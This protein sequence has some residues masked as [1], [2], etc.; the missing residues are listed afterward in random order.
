MEPAR[1]RRKNWPWFHFRHGQR[2]GQTFADGN[3]HNSI[4]AFEDGNDA[5]YHLY[6]YR[7][8]VFEIIETFETSEDGQRLFTTILAIISHSLSLLI[9]KIHGLI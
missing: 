8:T 6:I 7:G 3:H 5:T 9:P 2:R 1:I 4:I